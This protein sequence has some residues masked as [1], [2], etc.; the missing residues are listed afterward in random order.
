LTPLWLGDGCEGLSG[1]NAAVNGMR[2]ALAHQHRFTLAEVHK[3]MRAGLRFLEVRLSAQQCVM[4]GLR[5]QVWRGMVGAVLEETRRTTGFRIDA[6]RIPLRGRAGRRSAFDALDEAVRTLRVPLIL[7]R[8]GIYTVVGG[9]TRTSLL[10]FDGRGACWIS[11]R[12][13][14]VPGDGDDL[15]HVLFPS[16]FLALNV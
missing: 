2:L 8:G 15:R 13:C 12:V 6:E 10:L 1:L 3:L 16:A 4:N 7:S 14:G 5:V 9:T 11:K